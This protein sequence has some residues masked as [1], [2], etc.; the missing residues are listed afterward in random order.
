MNRNINEYLGTK[1]N[2]GDSE[3]NNYLLGQFENSNNMRTSLESIQNAL[4]D[5]SKINN[6]YKGSLTIKDTY[7]Y[8]S[9]IAS[10]ALESM[11]NGPFLYSSAP[12][13]ILDLFS[14]LGSEVIPYTP[15]KVGGVSYPVKI[16]LAGNTKFFDYK[17]TSNIDITGL[18]KENI[19]AIINS[20]PEGFFQT[21]KE[22]N[23]DTI[24]PIKPLLLSK[25]RSNN[26]TYTSEEV[27]YINI[28]IAYYGGGLNLSVVNTENLT[29]NSLGS[30]IEIDFLDSY[31]TPLESGTNLTNATVLKNVVL[32][33]VTVVTGFEPFKFVCMKNHELFGNTPNIQDLIKNAKGV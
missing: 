5:S 9:G 10:I 19:S 14:M 33:C 26:V 25:A 16:D 1:G 21:D 7:F 2:Y 28:P 29:N 12:S 27:E 22:I 3:L 24:F 23:I 31:L 4:N 15:T 32:R 13:M 20:L 17:D 18:I 8:N 30:E 6:I 11:F